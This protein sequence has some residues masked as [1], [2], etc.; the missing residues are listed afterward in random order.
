MKIKLYELKLFL[1]HPFKFLYE[2]LNLKFI[3]EKSYNKLI[4]NYQFER[5]HKF[6]ENINIFVCNGEIEHGGLTDRLQGILTTFYISKIL[7]RPFKIYWDSPFKL[8]KYLECNKYNWEITNKK[9]IYK[10][11]NSKPLIFFLYPRKYNLRNIL[12]YGILSYLLSKRNNCYHVYTNYKFPKCK[13]SHLFNELFIP[14]QY[15]KVEIERHLFAIG[16]KYWSISFR[17]RCL[18]NDFKESSGVVLNSQQK[19]ILIAKNIEELKV[20]LKKLP[21]DYKCLITSDSISFLKR[22]KDID[23]RIYIINGKMSH[24]DYN[25]ELLEKDDP[26]IKLFLDYYLI[27]NAERVYLFKTG[28]MY[29]SRF[30]EIAA[31]IGKKKFIYHEF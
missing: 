9:N 19:E 30:S 15:L 10:G 28:N 27:M 7:K 4:K 11:T 14:S 24:L 16:N 21:N 25:N 17:Y 18:L 20:F 5:K 29:R 13:F 22:V 6:N 12:G 26:W 31:L 2:K 1:S 8:N 23:P 3:N